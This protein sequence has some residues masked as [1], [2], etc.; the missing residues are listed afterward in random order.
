MAVCHHCGKRF[1]T[2]RAAQSGVGITD[3]LYF[4]SNRCKNVAK[5]Q[6]NTGRKIASRRTVFWII[7]MVA[8]VAIET[9]SEDENNSSTD[10]IELPSSP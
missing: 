1:D 2:K 10:N 8:L 7:L 6:G 5:K 9:C 4:C 3:S